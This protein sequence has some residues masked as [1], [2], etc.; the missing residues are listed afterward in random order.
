MANDRRQ[1]TDSTPEIRSTAG[2]Q[3][4]LRVPAR[5]GAQLEA[6]AQRENNGVIAVIRRLLTLALAEHG[7][8]A[9]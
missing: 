1:S 5:M 9:A 8:E 2:K 3:I 7:N 6:L 4:G